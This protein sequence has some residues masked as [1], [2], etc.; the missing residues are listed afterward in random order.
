MSEFWQ[1]F[2]WLRLAVQKA[3]NISWCLFWV[4]LLGVRFS[5]GVQNQ[6]PVMT[7]PDES[8]DES[9]QCP[10]PLALM[11]SRAEHRL[12]TPQ[13][14]PA[15]SFVLRDGQKLIPN[16]PAVCLQVKPTNPRRWIA[17]TFCQVRKPSWRTTPNHPLSVH[18]EILHKEMKNPGK[19]GMAQGQTG[20][21]RHSS[22]LEFTHLTPP[23][24]WL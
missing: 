19:I 15:L 4:F 22:P 23:L 21:P 17:C 18:P 10:V 5:A 20:S 14:Q 11:S 16:S 6:S 7:A 2:R 13:L 9:I 1:A 8:P 24:H 3:V 12:Q